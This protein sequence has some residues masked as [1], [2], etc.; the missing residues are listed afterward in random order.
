MRDLARHLGLSTGTITYY[1]HDRAAL[2]IAAMDAV[3]IL[4]SDWDRFH[5][6]PALAQ[7]T[8][9]TELFV[10]DDERKQRWGRFW[11]AYLAGAAHDDTLRRCQDER[12]ERQLRFF[13]RLIG[14]GMA[15]GEFTTRLNAD[16]EAARL[17]ALGNGL[18][19]QQIATPNGLAPVAARAILGAYLADLHDSAPG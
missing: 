16:G 15:A 19:M 14:K 9:L 3:Y 11:L 5:D 17:V 8:H 4:P 7:L 12:Y 2:L 13:A 10:L 1:F 6:A 18:A